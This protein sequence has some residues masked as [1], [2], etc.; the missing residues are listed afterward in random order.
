MKIKALIDPLK[1]YCCPK[2]CLSIKKI[3]DKFISSMNLKSNN[4]EFWVILI[5]IFFHY[6][7]ILLIF[8]EQKIILY[9]LVFCSNISLLLFDKI[10]R[11]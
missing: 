10:F 2:Y 4:A 8:F 5:I 6:F 7:V 1:I 11:L 3:I 9:L